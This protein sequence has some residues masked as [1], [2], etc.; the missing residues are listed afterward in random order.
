[1]IFHIHIFKTITCDNDLLSS[2]YEYASDILCGYN[3]ETNTNILLIK[4][5]P[6]S[7]DKSNFSIFENNY[8]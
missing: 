4:S 6:A 2:T 8:V 3:Y 5:I 7:G 1:M